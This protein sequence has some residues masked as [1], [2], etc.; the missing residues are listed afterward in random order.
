MSKKHDLPAMPFYFGDWMKAPEIRALPLDTRMIWFE[1]LG[2]MWESTE[3]GYLTINNSPISKESLSRMIGVPEVLLEQKLKQLLDFGVYS[4]RESDGAIYSRRMIRDEEIRNLRQKAGSVGGKKTFASHF[5]Q[6]KG[7]ANTEDEDEYES[8]IVDK[9]LKERTEQRIEEVTKEWNTFA[10]KHG[11]GK[12]IKL[13]DKRKAGVRSR[14][15]ELEFQWELILQEIENSDFL[16]GSTGW[17]VDFDFVFCSANNYLKILEG[18]YRNGKSKQISGSAATAE[19]GK[20]DRFSKNGNPKP[21][22]EQIPVESSRIIPR[23]SGVH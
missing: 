4:I 17:K 12:V 16:R 7:Q 20:Y 6:A 21:V 3:R 14:I 9:D 13:S 2:F 23:E 1:M 18:K 19:P 22:P 11:L 8:E 5:A 15:K 10:A